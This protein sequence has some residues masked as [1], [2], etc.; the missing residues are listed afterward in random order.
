[1]ST[2]ATPA[3]LREM[4]LQLKGIGDE[5]IKYSKWKRK[6]ELHILAKESYQSDKPE[7]DGD[8]WKL[9]G[10]RAEIPGTPTCTLPVMV[11][12]L[13]AYIPIGG[14][15][16]NS[17]KYPFTIIDEEGFLVKK[18]LAVWTKKWMMLTNAE[19]SGFSH[20]L[21]AAPS[22][23][24]AVPNYED[25]IPIQV[26][27]DYDQFIGEFINKHKIRHPSL[28]RDHISI[29]FSTFICGLDLFDPQQIDHHLKEIHRL[30]QGISS[31]GHSG[32]SAIG[33]EEIGFICPS[34]FGIEDMEENGQAMITE[35]LFHRCK[36]S[37]MFFN[38]GFTPNLKPIRAQ[39]LITGIQV[40]SSS[41]Y[42][43]RFLMLLG[44]ALRSQGQNIATEFSC[45]W[46]TIQ[47][48]LIAAIGDDRAVNRMLL[49]S[50]LG[51]KDF[52]G[53]PLV[54]LFYEVEKR[55]DKYMGV[56][57]TVVYDSEM[58]PQCL[59]TYTLYLKYNLIIEITV[60]LDKSFN[61]IR[62]CILR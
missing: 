60:N 32:T 59:N 7:D 10:A 47:E 14:R 39:E 40:A 37:G 19:A 26:K 56:Q 17:M 1:M 41:L 55:V 5:T 31:L 57:E 18:K 52:S 23:N 53:Q 51:S 4:D 50:S 27:E 58:R 2:P 12:R 16:K 33:M 22:D 61:A 42:F 44:Q 8:W 62:V 6:I 28:R 43:K 11:A 25:Y 21:V 30:E 20:L 13:M 29:F 48:A 15:S 35:N 45:N 49:V 3:T 36:A 54:F 9:S 24:Y 38:T 46:G 34:L